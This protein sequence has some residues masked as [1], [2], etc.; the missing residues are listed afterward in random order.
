LA[1]RAVL[2]GGSPRRDRL[3]RG[4][5]RRAFPSRTSLSVGFPGGGSGSE[6]A[7][8][9]L[10]LCGRRGGGGCWSWCGGHGVGAPNQIG[11]MAPPS[12]LGAPHPPGVVLR[13]F[14]AGGAGAGL[15]AGGGADSGRN[16]WLAV[17]ATTVATPAGAVFFLE[18]RQ[19]I[20]PPSLSL[21]DTGRNPK[22]IGLG[23]SDAPC[24]VTFLK[25]SPWISWG[26]GLA[27]FP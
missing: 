26:C 16:P 4:G 22:S 24:A 3:D 2:D 21:P 7:G 13:R 9:L 20:L 11:R 23:G 6:A 19:G 25:V 18:R 27:L 14:L 1:P 17:S 12:S 5:G 10:R 15:G 8:P